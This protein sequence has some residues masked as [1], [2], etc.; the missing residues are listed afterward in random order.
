MA[1]TTSSNRQGAML[2]VGLGAAQVDP[3]IRP[4]Q[5]RLVVACHNSPNSTTV[6]GDNDAINELKSVLLAEGIFARVVRTGGQAYHSH[7]MHV[8]SLPYLEF[9]E[10]ESTHAL[11]AESLKARVPMFSTVT[12]KLIEDNTIKAEYWIDN[13]TNRVLFNEAML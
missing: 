7:H 12:G 8:V 13:L 9:L 10:K 4:Y 11:S 3:Y 5:I 6:S 1:V 2:A